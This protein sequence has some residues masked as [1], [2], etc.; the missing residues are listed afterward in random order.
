VAAAATLVAASRCCCCRGLFCNNYIS[1]FNYILLGT[2]LSNFWNGPC[3][4]FSM[5]NRILS[6]Q[7]VQQNYNALKGRFNL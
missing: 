3:Y 5:Y 6:A 7:E 4:Q 1:N 2:R